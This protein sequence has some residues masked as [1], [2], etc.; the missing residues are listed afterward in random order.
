MGGRGAL[1][2]VEKEC[3]DLPSAVTVTVW[4]RLGASGAP[5]SS[6]S[7][8]PQLFSPR[9]SLRLHGAWAPC[10]GGFPVGI[11]DA[12]HTPLTVLP[13]VM[14]WPVHAVRS[15]RLADQVVARG[16]VDDASAA[17]QQGDRR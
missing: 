2:A 8:R 3:A 13:P 5:M 12:A 17:V 6:Y 16:R 15:P 10:D 4:R 7:V 1:H 9:H 14:R 11:W